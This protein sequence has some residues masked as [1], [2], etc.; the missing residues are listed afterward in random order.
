MGVESWEKLLGWV[1]RGEKSE[2]D[3]TANEFN[4]FIYNQVKGRKCLIFTNSRLESEKTVAMLKEVAA[5][6]NEPDIF[7]VHHGSLSAALR[8]ETEY[9]LRSST[10]PVVTAA[11]R[12]LELGIDLGTLERVVQL[13]APFTCSS[14]VQ[15]LGR[16]GRRESPAQMRFIT[17]HKFE[18]NEN[19]FEQIPWDLIRNIAIIQLYLEER[20]VEG[21]SQKKYPYSLLFHQTLSAL[22]QAECTP[23]E[24]ARCVL[25]LP[26]F[27]A[28]TNEEYKSLLRHAIKIDMIQRTDEGS[29]IV[30]LAGERLTNSYRFYSVFKDETEY[31]VYTKH[32]NIGTVDTLPEINEI[33]LLAGKRWK[34]M[35]VDEDRKRVYVLPSHIYGEK[36]WHSQSTFFLDDKIVNRMR[37]VLMEDAAYPYLLDRAQRH[38][39]NAREV[40]RNAGILDS[41]CSGEG[42][43]FLIHPW[44]GGRKHHTL[45]F[46]LRS[47]YKEPLNISSVVDQPAEFFME[48]QTDRP[49][50]EFM[51]LLCSALQTF[52]LS[53]LDI[54]SYLL[55]RERYDKYL[56]MELLRSA[57]RTDVLDIPGI[58][59]FFTSMTSRSYE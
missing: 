42:N 24:L 19:A 10:E 53:E 7:H 8:R 29:L 57:Y 9:T 17:A 25:T 59:A 16:S 27:E 39:K 33:L 15:R 30:G 3:V 55:Y 49:A 32:Q 4:D 37:D 5:K 54:P 1:T 34:V 18:Q 2:S 47:V 44:L 41:Y 36:K 40:S 13:G 35:D 31:T 51:E 14:F 50:S 48:I 22:A 11:T 38:L 26:P 58:Q 28:V 52:D 23:R 12:T 20:W 43:Q 21:I 45:S 56:P 6:Q 46:L